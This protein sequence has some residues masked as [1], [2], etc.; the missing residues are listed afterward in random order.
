MTCVLESV[1]MSGVSMPSMPAVPV[2]FDGI[3]V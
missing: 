1:G 2:V 3:L